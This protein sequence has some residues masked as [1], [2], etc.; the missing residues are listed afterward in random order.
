[1]NCYCG[2][3]KKYEKCCSPFLVGKSIP[4]TPEELMRSRYSA[5]CIEDFRYIIDTYATAQ[6]QNLRLSDIE[7]SATETK[8]TALTVCKSSMENEI[9]QV[10]FKAFY[11]LSSQ[12]FMLHEVSDFIKEDGHWRYTKGIIQEDSGKLD[13]QRNAPCPCLSKLKFK[14]CCGK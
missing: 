4:C 6:R 1:M 3:S 2:S 8:W 7:A 12:F 11:R 5:Y 14:R 9:G 13:I 10:Q